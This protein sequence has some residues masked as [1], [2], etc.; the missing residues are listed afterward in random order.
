M[1]TTIDE[2]KLGALVE[3]AVGDFGSTLNA[4]LVVVGDRLGLFEGLVEGGP[5]TP[6][7]LAE[8]TGTVERNVL[9]W[10]NAQAAAGYVTYGDGRYSLSPE[11]AEAL[12]NPDSP[13]FVLGG[14]QAMSAAARSI[15]TLTDRFRT[16]TGMAWHEHHDDLFHGTERFFRPGYNANLVQAW[17]PALDGVEAKLDSGARVADVGCGHGASTIIMARAFPKSTFVGFDY[18]EESI[19]AARKAA[20]E[21]GVSDR[22]GFEVASAKELG[23]QDY[24]LICYFDCLHDM[25]DPVGALVHA[26]ERLAADGTI[27]LVEPRAGD[28]VTEN[29]NPVGRVFYAASTLICTPASQSQEVGLALGAQ[30]G[31]ARLGEV[32]DAAGFGR[33]RVAAETPFN[34]VLEVRV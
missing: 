21:A 25:G 33:F 29:L 26:R 32:A 19:V 3:Q 13:A 34:L 8:R 20:S 4:A 23:G 24:D 9:E 7:E 28:D 17:L 14:F 10:L 18:H 22:V 16:G 12:T 31:P 27:L 5:Q 30:A 6:T 11:Q 1:N 15:D 2:T